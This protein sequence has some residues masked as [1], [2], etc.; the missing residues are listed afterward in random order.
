MPR[1]KAI[2]LLSGGLDSATTLA[3]ARREGFEVNAI[4]FRYGQRHE[5]EIEAARNVASL[6]SVGNHLIVD[7][8]LRMIGH[9]ALTADIAVPKQRSFADMADGIPETYVPA[10]NTV[11]SR[12]RLPGRR[13]WVRLTSSSG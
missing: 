11:F 10:R 12:S 7:I 3:L 4:S 13:C 6:F 2:V 5:V 1:A 8:D 9:S